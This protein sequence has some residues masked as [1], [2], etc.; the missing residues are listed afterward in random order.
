MPLKPPAG[1]EQGEARGEKWQSFDAAFY[2][3]YQKM[4]GG[5]MGC[6][7]GNVRGKG[8][9]LRRNVA[10]HFDEGWS[11]GQAGEQASKNDLLRGAA[12]KKERGAE[13]GE[14]MAP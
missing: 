9:L 12:S 11:Q 10:L 5:L 6:L 4:T 2:F 1:V 13:N 8:K 3:E 7:K 14:Q